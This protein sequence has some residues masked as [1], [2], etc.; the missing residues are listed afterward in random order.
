[1]SLYVW[2]EAAQDVAVGG[3]LALGSGMRCGTCV[4]QNGNGVTLNAPGLYR[5]EVSV[6]GTTDA[7]GVLTVEA[8]VD[9]VAVPGATASET[10]GVAGDLVSPSLAFMVRA[11]GCRCVS[12]PNVTLVNVGDAGSIENVAMTVTRVA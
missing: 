11:D 8:R 10:V 6:N 7:A 9:G 4:V 12:R 2:N 5:F 3:T 1:M